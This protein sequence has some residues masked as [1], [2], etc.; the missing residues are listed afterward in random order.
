VSSGECTTS[1][2]QQFIENFGGFEPAECLAGAVVQFVSDRVKLGL[3]VAGQVSPFREILV[4]LD[5]SE[6]SRVSWGVRAPFTDAR[7]ILRV[8]NGLRISARLL[9]FYDPPASA[10]EEEVDW[11]KRRNFHS[12]FAAL[13]LTVGACLDLDRLKALLPTPDEQPLPRQI[14][15]RDVAAIELGK[16]PTR[17]GRHRV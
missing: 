1:F 16:S 5:P 12:R 11:M 8:A 9:G 4:E 14:G 2:D 15:A 7:V 6:V 10:A 3:G 13:A 17:A